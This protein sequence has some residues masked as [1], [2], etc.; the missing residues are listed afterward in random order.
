MNVSHHPRAA[1][2]AAVRSELYDA[3]YP[4]VALY[5][6]NC[7]YPWLR[8][9][10]RGKRPKGDEWEVRARRD[11]PEAVE[12]SPELDALETGILCDG[13][14]VLDLDVE[15]A[16]AV[17]LLRAK[18]TARFGEAPVRYR[19][20]SP[21]VALVYRA[22]EGQPGKR[23]LKGKLGKI[24]VLGL[25]QQ[26]AAF[27]MHLSGVDLRW[28]PEGLNT[29][30]R[31]ALPAVSEAQITAFFAEAAPIIGATEQDTRA[32]AD[33]SGLPHVPSVHGPSADPLDVTAA[34]A[35]IPN[36]G[37][38]DWEHWNK[39][40]MATYAA[41][42]GSLVGFAAWTAWSERNSAHDLALC[43]ERWD[44]YPKAEPSSIGA[45]TL[46]HTGARG[47][48]GL[49]QADQRQQGIRCFCEA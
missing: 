10:D 25:G 20:N 3:G 17:A 42:G 45:G 30:P 37:A 28:E 19:A 16:V 35:V 29:V 8:P 46:F 7:E 4:P 27:G 44:H 31:E 15:D 9:T 41:T 21:R 32:A 36:A 14:R 39:I 11:P 49:G 40:G 13:L 24:E 47:A 12:G 18:A 1:A 34:L 5:S 22:A 33:T 38:P 26:L 43:Q 48:A 2:A 6:W 23:V